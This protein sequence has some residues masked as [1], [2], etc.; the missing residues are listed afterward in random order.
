MLGLSKPELA[1]NACFYIKLVSVTYGYGLSFEDLPGHW[2]GVVNGAHVKW[3]HFYNSAI[4][5]GD[6]QYLLNALF[7]FIMQPQLIL[8]GIIALSGFA[9]LKLLV[10][11]C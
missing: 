5:G 10:W 7:V 11:I 1:R 2:P 8:Y 6:C 3:S 4:P 9:R